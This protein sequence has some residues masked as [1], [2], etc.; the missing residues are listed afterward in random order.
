MAVTDPIAIDRSAKAS[1]M[2]QII[3]KGKACLNAGR[4]ILIFPEGTRIPPG[5]IGKYRLGGARL[6]VDSGYPILPVAHNAGRFWFRRKF[7]KRPGTIR[8][9]FGPLIES[10]GKTPEQLLE[11][12]K[13]WIEKTMDEI[14]APFRTQ[15]HS[16]HLK[17]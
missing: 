13:N 9:V 2:A 10:K 12:T 4:W 1:A 17:S 15:E 8:V 3:K 16:S 7:I 6:A 5:Q 11:L 14:D